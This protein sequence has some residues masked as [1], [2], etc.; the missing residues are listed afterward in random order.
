MEKKLASLHFLHNYFQGQLRGED[1][2]PALLPI[3]H[4]KKSNSEYIFNHNKF[5]NQQKEIFKYW[6]ESDKNLQNLFIINY[7]SYNPLGYNIENDFSEIYI[8]DLNLNITHN[9][10]YLI[11]KISSK[12]CIYNYVM[13]LGEDKKN[14]LIPIVIFDVENYFNIKLDEWDYV[15]KLYDEKKYIIILNPKYKIY[16]EKFYETKGTDGLVCESPNETIL[17]NNETELKNFLGEN[18]TEID[19]FTH[20]KNNADLMF[21]KKYYEKSIYYYEKCLKLVE[22]KNEAENKIL[23][24]KIYSDLSESYIKYGY[25][26]KA[27][28]FINKCLSNVKKIITNDK[29]SFKK[30]FIIIS[31]IKQIKCFVNLRKYKEANEL[32][33]EIKNQKTLIINYN[34]EKKD[35]DNLLNYKIIKDLCIKIEIG[36]SNVMGKYNIK[37]MILKEKTDFYLENGDY[38]NPKIEFSYDKQKGIKVIAKQDIEQGEYI[39][40]EKAI[41]CSR[42]HVPDNLFETNCRLKF[43]NYYRT[44]IETDEV[45]YLMESKNEYIECVN[46]IIKKIKKAPY[47]YINFFYFFNGENLSQNLIDRKLLLPQNILSSLNDEKIEKCFKYNKYF[48]LRYFYCLTKIG[49]GLWNNLSFFNNCCNPN[50][51]NFGIGDFIF[52]TSNKKILKGDEITIMYLSQPK[53]Y[54]GRKETLKNIYNFDCNCD[55]CKIEERFRREQPETAKKFDDYLKDIYDKIPLSIENFAAF[56]DKNKDILPP[57]ELSSGYFEIQSICSDFE[58]ALKYSEYAEKYSKENFF[59][60]YK[61]NANKIADFCNQQKLMG[62][63]KF[64]NKLKELDIKLLDIGNKFFNLSDD[65]VFI[66]IKDCL[67]KRFD[68]YIL[69]KNYEE[70]MKMMYGCG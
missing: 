4:K 37:E 57:E 43:P 26:T 19:S 10:K 70:E 47:D 29:N 38:I 56:L 3:N 64:V 32:L 52:V 14:R 69:Q 35:L 36:L 27:L 7:D 51:S 39:L 30:T 61:M 11:L 50:T 23:T 18:I 20:L 16:G 8:D 1:D 41:Y 5:I 24:S 12:I 15:Q 33:L 68:D 2:D 46:N 25:Y 48:S 58:K 34:L 22:N 31:L 45:N 67:Q 49:V 66:L 55:Y 42:K 21:T 40:V 9:K 60:I 65:E 59:E 63:M 13:F 62:N 28:E 44:N 6:R 54:E 17:F 53:Y